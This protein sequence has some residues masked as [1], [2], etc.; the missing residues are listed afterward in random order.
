[1][2]KYSEKVIDVPTGETRKIN[3]IET[4]KQVPIYGPIMCYVYISKSK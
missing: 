1:M 2:S 3:A 4:A